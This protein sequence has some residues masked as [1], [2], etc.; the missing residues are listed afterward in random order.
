MAQVTEEGTDNP[1]HNGSVA[2][3]IA[4]G[5]LAL[6]QI[7]GKVVDQQGNPVANAKLAYIT[8]IDKE[9]FGT[10]GAD[11]R[12]TFPNLRYRTVVAIETANG[13]DFAVMSPLIKLHDLGSAKFR[14]LLPDGK[15]AVGVSMNPETIYQG[16]M[17][18][19]V[20]RR[21]RAQLAKTT[22]ANGEC[23]FDGLPLGASVGVGTFDHRFADLRDQEPRPVIGKDPVLTTVK[24][25]PG[26]AISG[27][28]LDA[29]GNPVPRVQVNT[30]GPSGS[31]YAFT[32][33][34]GDYSIWQLPGAG[35]YKVQVELDTLKTS[36]VASAKHGLS[37]QPG[38]TLSNEDFKLVRGQRFSGKLTFAGSGKPSAADWISVQEVGSDDQWND[39]TDDSGNFSIQLLPGKY[40][41]TAGQSAPQPITISD[42]TDLRLDLVE[43]EKKT[44]KVLNGTVVDESGKPVFGATI[45]C[46]ASQM[47]GADDIV[48]DESGHF[49]IDGGVE[50][51][52]EIMAQKGRMVTPQ[53]VTPGPD[54]Q[55][56]LVLHTMPKTFI[57]GMVYG[58]EKP[59]RG[60]AV[61][62]SRWQTDQVGLDCDHTLT[63]ANGEFSVEEELPTKY[64]VEVKASGFAETSSQNF[65]L[66]DPVH[67]K[68]VLR[69]PIAD[70]FV[71]GKVVDSKGRPVAG[72]NISDEDTDTRTVTG[73]D[74]RFR[75]S[76][77][78]RGKTVVNV[79][80]P[81]GIANEEVP[82]GKSD[83][84]ITLE[85]ANDVSGDTPAAAPA[86]A[87]EPVVPTKLD[88]VGK[89]APALDPKCWL[90]L[91]NGPV[92]SL[93]GHVVILDFWGISCKPCVAELPALNAFQKKYAARGLRVIGWQDS[94]DKVADVM[95]FLKKHP[96]AFPVGV[97]K[98]NPKTGGQLFQLLQVG[99]PA[100][101]VVG[102]DGKIALV[103]QD[104]QTATDLAIALLKT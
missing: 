6:G 103:T 92:K 74:G 33:S 101:V 52:S 34:S 75:L 5:S 23:R 67:D 36:W 22:D 3:L 60:A 102:K 61:Q 82:S 97:D 15:P 16:H 96:L 73:K 18:F 91:V 42:G 48:S 71:A 27:R 59:L 99:T 86:A 69:L 35:T 80:S 41:V 46:S 54:G 24:L 70:S 39:K 98:G 25:Q 50:P 14:I 12:F 13:L 55:V 28:V 76:N 8:G 104:L 21:L 79:D 85:F 94:Y 17:G 62:I 100:Q 43:P 57:R 4:W 40:Q 95:R 72:A 87:A 56:N 9:E 81:K 63:D 93:K 77:V 84:V 19:G 78:A 66:T 47:P 29:N 26:A 58:G 38:Q 30:W 64:S 68:L 44:P 20:S 45:L 90:N 51:G 49:T 11:G 37:P 1:K 10:T 89:A 2:V 83:V 7:S 53:P 88:W 65:K 32:D 31:G